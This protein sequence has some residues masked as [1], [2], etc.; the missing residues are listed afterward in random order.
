[1]CPGGFICQ[2]AKDRL[3]CHSG[4]E[5]L[6]LVYHALQLALDRNAAAQ[7]LFLVHL[8][9]L[10]CQVGGNAVTQFLNGVNACCLKEFGKLRT[11]A[12]NTEEVGMISPAQN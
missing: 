9:E 12:V 7:V 10:G 4:L 1:M 2:V 3:V 8:D 5:F 6:G 11:D